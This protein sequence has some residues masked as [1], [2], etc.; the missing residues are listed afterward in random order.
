[1]GR[2]LMFL[3]G[4]NSGVD[5]VCRSDR[6]HFLQPSVVVTFAK[7]SLC[8]WHKEYTEALQKVLNLMLMCGTDL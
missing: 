1:M 7:V 2:W 6:P 4:N 3:A 5:F 8:I